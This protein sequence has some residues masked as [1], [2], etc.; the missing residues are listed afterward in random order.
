MIASVLPVM[1]SGQRFKYFIAR[2]STEIKGY[3]RG[4]KMGIKLD[5]VQFIVDQAA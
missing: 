2:V 5:L 1:E 3:F 4:Y